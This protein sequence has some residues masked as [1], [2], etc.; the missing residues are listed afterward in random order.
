MYESMDELEASVRR[1][2]YRLRD[3]GDNMAAIRSRE[4][5]EDGAVTVEVD[6]NGAL[7]DLE[8]S[9]TIS[10]MTPEQFESAVVT[11]AYA[12]A[13]NAFAERA[14][15]VNTFNDEVAGW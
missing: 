7:L 11:T 3:L 14:D 8:L 6:G 9:E 2:L 1:R 5:S 10:R 13:V 4:T 12:A 15:L